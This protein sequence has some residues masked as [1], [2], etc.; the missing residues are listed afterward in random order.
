MAIELPVVYGSQSTPADANYPQGSGKNDA[1]AGDQTGTPYDKEWFND[2]WGFFNYL[3]AYAGLT[4]SGTPDNAQVS[5]YGQA[6]DQ[7]INDLIN[8]AITNKLAAGDFDA[9]INTVI[10]QR[11]Q[12]VGG[13]LKYDANNNGNLDG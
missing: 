12:V 4:P 9:R 2:I 8:T 7:L 1:V 3:I 13:V 11:L 5:Q 10:S 6:L